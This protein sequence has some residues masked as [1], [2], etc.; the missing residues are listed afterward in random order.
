MVLIYK[1]PTCGGVMTYNAQKQLLECSHCQT[2]MAADEYDISDLRAEENKTEEFNI[3]SYRCPSCGAELITDDYTAAT[4][5]SYCGSP[6]IINDRLSEENAPDLIIPFK[7]NKAA[8]LEKL[9]HWCRNGLF[10][11]S[12]FLS[13]NSLKKL[14]GIYVPFWLYDFDTH[15]SMN[16]K[17][18]KVRTYIQGDKEYTE[19]SYYEVYRETVASYEKIPADASEKMEDNIMDALEPFYYLDLEDFDMAYFS[20]YSA[21]KY[22]FT[23]EDMIAR[24]VPRA[25]GYAESITRNTM[26]DYDSINV[27]SADTDAKMTKATYAFL[28]VWRYAYRYKGIDYIFS[29]NGQ[30]GKIIGKPPKSA[31]KIFIVFLFLFLAVFWGGSLLALYL[32]WGGVF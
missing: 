9:K 19:T 1:C 30:T 10:T 5:C 8:T 26:R 2:S 16:A 3:T 21:E 7:F 22:N 20:G 17:C 27:T 6:T 18:S 28:P 23:A 15:C 12:D 32:S 11:P 31:S 25:K 14:S 29:M 4:T 13:Q 24:V